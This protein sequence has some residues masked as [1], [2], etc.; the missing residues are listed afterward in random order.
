MPSVSSLFHLRKP[1][2]EDHKAGAQE[3]A[4]AEYTETEQPAT[5]ALSNPDAPP[6]VAPQFAPGTG[7]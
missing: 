7:P 6:N 5:R 4:E 1:N 3:A 2:H